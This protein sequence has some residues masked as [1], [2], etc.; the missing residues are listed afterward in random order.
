MFIQVPKSFDGLALC[1]V[2]GCL[3][4]NVWLLPYVKHFNWNKT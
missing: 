1:Q 4:L 3:E 2:Y